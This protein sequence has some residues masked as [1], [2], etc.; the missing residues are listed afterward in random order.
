MVARS[1]PMESMDLDALDPFPAREPRL[2]LRN[3]HTYMIP[4]L[5]QPPRGFISIDIRTPDRIR[6]DSVSGN[7][8]VHP[9]SP[10]QAPDSNIRR[11]ATTRPSINQMAGPERDEYSMS[12]KQNRTV[13]HA[14]LPITARPKPRRVGSRASR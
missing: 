14:K 5:Y 7:Q 9:G 1:C 12:S 4:T 2:G 13:N 3:Q 8:D 11:A 10:I 6:V